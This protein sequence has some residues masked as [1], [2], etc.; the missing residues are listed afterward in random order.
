MSL[1]VHM[2]TT[3]ALAVHWAGILALTSCSFFMPT[4]LLFADRLIGSCMWDGERHLSELYMG[5]QQLHKQ[6]HDRWRMLE[7]VA[8][9]YRISY[10]KMYSAHTALAHAQFAQWVKAISG[11]NITV[12]HLFLHI[13]VTDYI[14]CIV[15]YN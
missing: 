6:P 7:N 15:S 10:F 2:C 13:P 5:P 11:L 12:K 4:P 1:R 8:C 3:E 14:D 9:V